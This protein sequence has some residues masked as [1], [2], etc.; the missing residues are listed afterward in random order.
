MQSSFSHVSI[1]V[2]AINHTHILILVNTYDMAMVLHQWLAESTYDTYIGKVNDSFWSNRAAHE[3][4]ILQLRAMF[5][6]SFH[7]LICH[8][9]KR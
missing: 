8:L 4:N 5:S 2:S 3:T 1:H 7:R 6:K 9:Q